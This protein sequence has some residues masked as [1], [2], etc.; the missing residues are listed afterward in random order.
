MN[1]IVNAKA[2]ALVHYIIAC[3]ESSKYKNLMLSDLCIKILC[4][5][6]N[7]EHP[8]YGMA[9][10]EVPENCKRLL[11]ILWSSGIM[12]R[13]P[14]LAQHTESLSIAIAMEEDQLLEAA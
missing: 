2:R 14:E 9:Y 10:Q 6:I 5:I 12:S 4:G 1:K 13:F 7:E 11:Q 8:K 3:Q